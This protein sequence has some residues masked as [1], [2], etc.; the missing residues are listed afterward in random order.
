MLLKASPP[1][2]PVNFKFSFNTISNSTFPSFNNCSVS[3][4]I[5]VG[6]PKSGRRGVVAVGAGYTKRPLETPGAY[7]LVDE[8]S[9]D[10]FIVW[11]G[12]DDDDHQAPIPSKEVLHWEPSKKNNKDKINNLEA[13]STEDA[14]LMNN[15]G[16]GI[17]RPKG[18]IIVLCSFFSPN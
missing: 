2:L 12:T 6:G 18:A 8:E 7:E 3:G 4:E 10:K 1:A 11:G 17:T 5:G 9:G 16:D 14:P 13:N 15:S